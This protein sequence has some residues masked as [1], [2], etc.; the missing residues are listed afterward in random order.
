[1][2]GVPSHQVQWYPGAPRLHLAGGGMGML[3]PPRH[4]A[5][6]ALASSALVSSC[7][8]CTSIRHSGARSQAA[9]SVSSLSSAFTELVLWSELYVWSFALRH[10]LEMLH[11]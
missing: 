8:A 11:W 4:R 2:V 6:L 1:M 10:F 5:L 9:T 3:E 7:S